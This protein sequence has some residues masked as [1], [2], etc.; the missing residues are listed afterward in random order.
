MSHPT[1][2]SVRTPGAPAPQAA[3]ELTVRLSLLATTRDNHVLMVRDPHVEGGWQLPGGVVPPGACP[4]ATARQLSIK[5]TGY[6]QEATHALAITLGHGPSGYPIALDY[7]LD[8]GRT[9]TPPGGEESLAADARWRPMREL[10]DST[11]LVQNA[12]LALTNGERLPVLINGDQPSAAWSD[13][14]NPFPSA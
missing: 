14:E 9:D 7:V 4:V 1:P 13:A 10:L 3:R 11:P 6:Y 8:G 12:L 5:Q 2:A